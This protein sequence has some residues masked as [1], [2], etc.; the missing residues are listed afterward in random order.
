PSRDLPAFE[1]S[2]L[3]AQRKSTRPITGRRRF[4]TSRADASP[5]RAATAGRTDGNALVMDGSEVLAAAQPA[6]D[7]KVR[8]RA[9]RVPIRREDSYPHWSASGEDTAPVMGRRG[10]GAHP[11]LSDLFDNPVVGFRAHDV[12]AA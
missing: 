8:V 5:V 9:P 1:S 6:L 7:R 4:D 3:V 12:A 10:F 11:V 2:R